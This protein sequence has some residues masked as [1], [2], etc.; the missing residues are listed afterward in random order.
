MSKPRGSS[1]SWRD[2][3][4]SDPYVQRARAEGYR[5]RA[6]YKLDELLRT[7]GLTNFRNRLVLDLGAAPG[8]WSQLLARRP[9][10]APEII[11]TDILPMDAIA[12]VEFI[13]GDF[14][15]D[16][17]IE[18]IRDK[19]GGRRADLVMSDMA[20]NM[21]G[22]RSVDQPKAMYL[23]ELA[24]ELARETLID[25]GTFICKVFHGEGF[26]DYVRLAHRLFGKVSVKK[27]TAS[28]DTSREV[29]VLARNYR[30]V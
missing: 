21:S 2:R 23:A 24:M 27:P 7:A 5:G 26:D 10:N 15:D 9:N 1:K 17:V 14:T 8:S 12:G 29:Y 20:P 13:Q 30:L 4:A 11:A 22:N 16:V 18:Q 6:V 19:M 28:R 3:Q 25:R